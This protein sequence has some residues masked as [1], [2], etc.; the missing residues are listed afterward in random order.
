MKEL[1]IKTKKQSSKIVE[2][3]LT[4]I[5][6]FDQFGKGKIPVSKRLTNNC[7]IYTRVSSKRQEAGYSLDT[8]LKDNMEFARKNEY[9]VLGYFGGTY[10]SAS[11]DERKEFN[12]MLQFCK[13]TK[14]KVT[15]IIVHM[16]DR[17]SRS[18]ANAI[19]IK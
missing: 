5:T 10:E 16:V 11:T 12:R 14:D 19:Y 2:D 17:F 4:E 18:G 3:E 7:V 13:R 8:Q 15:Y 1:N 9:N 6:I